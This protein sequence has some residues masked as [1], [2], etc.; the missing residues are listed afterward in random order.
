MH[1]S[2]GRPSH[3]THNPAFVKVYYRWHPLFNQEIQIVNT[4]TRGG[5]CFH[6]VELNDSH[7]RLIPAWMTDKVFC[8]RFILEESAYCSVQSLQQVRQFLDAL[9]K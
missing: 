6:T 7:C 9:D 4:F 3:N 1:G 5:E 2:E 8:Q